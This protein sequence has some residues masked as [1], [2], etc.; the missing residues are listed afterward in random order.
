MI[1]SRKDGMCR[2]IRPSFL[3]YL[4]ARWRLSDGE[5]RQQES[6][7]LRIS[8]PFMSQRDGPPGNRRGQKVG[9]KEMKLEEKQEM[10]KSTIKGR[11]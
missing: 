3:R 8:L 6:E 1:Y 2:C 11:E 9:L 10:G 5:R 4:Q 7:A